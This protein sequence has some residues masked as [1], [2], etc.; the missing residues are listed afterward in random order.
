M[1]LKIESFFLHRKFFLAIFMVSPEIHS[2]IPH[3]DIIKQTNCIY[4][5]YK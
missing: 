2:R 3:P 5:I 4:L 1:P